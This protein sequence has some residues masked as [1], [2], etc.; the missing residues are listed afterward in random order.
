MPLVR[1]EVRNQY[2]LGLPELYRE[3]DKEDP[4]AVLDGVA[5]AGLV[6]ILRQLGDLAEFAAEV[7]HGL[8]EQVMTTSSRSHKMMVRVRK[9]ETALP[10]LEKAILG[11]KSHLHFAYTS[12]SQWH[13][14]VRNEQ[15]HF[16]YS[17]LPRFIMDSYE[18]CRSPPRLHLLDKFDTGG[19]GSCLKRYSDPTFFKIA[20]AGLA[21]EARVE[22]VPLVKKAHKNKF[23]ST[24]F[25]E[26]TSPSVST[27]DDALKSELGERSNSLDSRAGSGYI[28]CIFHPSYDHQDTEE[29]VP[30]ELPPPQV[31]IHTPSSLDSASLD[32]Q[33][34]VGEDIQNVFSPEQTGASSSCVTWD[35]KTEIMGPSRHKYDCD[36]TTE[37]LPR[38][39]NVDT[40]NRGTVTSVD[41]NHFIFGVKDMPAFVNGGNQLDDIDSETD[42][43]VD[44]LNTIE[45]EPESDLECQTKR[46]VERYSSLNNIAVEGV[47]HRL[48][49]QHLAADVPSNFESDTPSHTSLNEVISDH[50]TAEISPDPHMA[51]C[52]SS[53]NGTS[54][55]NPNSLSS[56]CDADIQSAK[57]A[58]ISTTRATLPDIDIHRTAN[59]VDGPNVET[60]VSNVSS[61]GSKV[62]NSE[63]SENRSTVS[64]PCR[65]Q[66]S[67][68]LPSGVQ[69]VMFWTNGGLLGLEPSKPP[70]F[71]VLDVVNQDSVA[72]SRDEIVDPSSPTNILEG[73]GNAVKA[74]VVAKSSG[75]FEQP[76]STCSTSIHDGN[77]V[78][79]P[80]KRPSWRISPTDLDVKLPESSDFQRSNHAQGKTS[81]RMLD[82]TNG[83]LA[84]SFQRQVSLLKDDNLAS[85]G[86]TF[87]EHSRS[88]SSL[89]SPT[90]SPPLEHMKISFQPIDGFEASR[91]KL[92]FPDGT[93]H[94]ESS[95]DMFPSFQLV[96]EPADLLHDVGSDSDDDTFCRSSPYMSDDCLST[97]SESNSERWE[98]SESPK[99]KDHELYDAF[100]RISSAESVSSSLE[101]RGT[102]LGGVPENHAPQSSVIEDSLEPSQSSHL[103]ELPSIDTLNPLFKQELAN[104]SETKYLLESHH[105]NETTPPPPP[106]PPAQWRET[107]PHLD[108]VTEK[109]DAFSETQDR[110]CDLKLL[111][112][113]ISLQPKPASVKRDQIET[114]AITPKRKQPD[115]QKLIR[116]DTNE[117]INGGD[118]DEKDDFLNQIRTKVSTHLVAFALEMNLRFA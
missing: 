47:A 95:G 24:N 30:K 117:T 29:H 14:T 2:G 59:G 6:G 60:V 79:N 100:C 9:I 15:N 19:P 23:A 101:I 75:I 69:S 17:D 49:A 73:D 99:S 4:K 50:N 11:Q 118:M 92:K 46:E 41:E 77:E 13:A 89:T 112:S 87:T 33:N 70:V 42:N 5:V 58:G 91:L 40:P 81:S 64:S 88:G 96:P 39:F 86:R 22:K 107:K 8:Q 63:A 66:K 108:V 1:V 116:Q 85:S 7:F 27:V 55:D 37:V 35:E 32:G 105:L 68:S 56:E 113:T 115:Q 62:L 20:S 16:I 51:A 72:K 52:S 28:E 109:E 103:F 25:D 31:K 45:S 74:D 98:P 57:V 84:N 67:T 83:R 104:D 94:S 18:E 10:P 44:A 61:S 76:S 26:R 82:F 71:N 106:L 38:N 111:A 90:S 65:F 3:A 12:G 110:T 54:G 21:T 93:N 80:S 48:A 43:Y 97:Y 78:D 34:R 53:N 114:L 102:V 36:E